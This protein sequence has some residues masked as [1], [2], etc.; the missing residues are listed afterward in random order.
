M[1][2]P[3]R[4]W[5]WNCTSGNR[6]AAAMQRNVPAENANAYGTAVAVPPAAAAPNIKS[7]TPIG[8]KPANRKFTNSTLP[9]LPPP[10]WNSVAT[11]MAS[12]GLCSKITRN[13]PKPARAGAT[14][15]STSRTAATL[16]AS[17]T[18]SSSECNPMPTAAPVQVSRPTG[19]CAA[20]VPP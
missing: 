2:K 5:R 15:G 18:P 9:R 8:T 11:V 20:A 4:S 13:V 10:A 14:P 12:N 6:S 16:A 3:T 17:A 1:D 7:T 19:A